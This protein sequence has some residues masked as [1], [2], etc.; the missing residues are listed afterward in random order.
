MQTYLVII[1]I[2]IIIIIVSNKNYKQ[3]IQ[4]NFYT[5]DVNNIWMYWENLPGKKKSQYLDLCYKT[6]KKNC[7]KNFKI[8]LL[9]E[10]SVYNYIPDLKDNLDE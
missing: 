6:I 1:I 9:N 4:E 2:V 5:G 8:H 3:E 7:S 10:K